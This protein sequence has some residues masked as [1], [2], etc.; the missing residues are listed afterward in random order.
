[1]DEIFE[2]PDTDGSDFIESF[3]LSLSQIMDPIRCELIL[4]GGDVRL[5]GVAVDGRVIVRLM[6]PFTRTCE[7]KREIVSRIEGYLKER[8]NRVT[9]VLPVCPRPEETL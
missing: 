6:G 1:M 9:A 5:A 3:Y 4:S 2:E 8:D 7:G